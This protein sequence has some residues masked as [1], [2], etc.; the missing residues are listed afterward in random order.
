ML[1]ALTV[2]FGA[3]FAEA[4]VSA[5]PPEPAK[6]DPSAVSATQF[7][8]VDGD[9]CE[10][11]HKGKQALSGALKIDFA[12][13]ILPHENT[14]AVLYG[15]G[16]TSLTGKFD[17][18]QLP[19]GWLCDVA[20]DYEKPEV[21]AKNFRPDHA[22][23]FPGA[24]GFGKYTL[25][26]R[27]G[28]VIAVTNLNDSGPGS[29]RAA[30]KAKGPRI[31][32]FNVS[33]TIVLKSE[34]EIK[35]PYITIAGQ[36]APGDGICVSNH[37]VQ[38]D[39][40]DVVIRYMRFRPGAA[41]GVTYDGFGGKGEQAIIDHC[42]VSWGVD[43]VF[44]INKVHNFT[45]Q[46]CMATES[47]SNSIHKKG[48]HGYGG[49]WGGPGGSWH[50]NILAHHS[51]RNPRA[52]GNVD[53]GLMDYRNN[54][55]YNWGYQ[56]AYGGELWP[57]NWINNYYKSG[58]ATDK[59]V[60]HRIFI[61][62]NSHGR[63]Y[64]DGNFVVGYPEISKDNWS[65]G[66]D[67][68]PDGDATEATLRVNEP[69]VVAPVRTQPAEEAYELVLKQAGAS[70]SRDSV[71]SRIINEIRTGTAK[72]GATYGGGGKGIIDSPED[73]GGW[74]ALKS[75]LAPTDTDADGMPDDWEISHGLDPKQAK[76][77]SADRDGDGYTNVEEYINS[78]APP[79]YST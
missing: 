49:L 46:W 19:K 72:F 11:I 4:K 62:A 14:V 54:V 15:K 36:T 16:V 17:K 1:I 53:S 30:C 71:D 5:L 68:S 8:I 67:F 41:S 38:F 52:S 79:V 48:K 55:V 20:Y 56:S 69:F 77:G 10:S 78:L 22:P 66:I 37:A 57:R 13:R 60:K 63:M 27:G 29:L 9:K 26:G 43:E 7:T 24:E 73:V 28:R 33:G 70:R 21:V 39:T 23:A 12:G 51:S 64:C 58:P 50:H 31:V 2:F 75:T 32:V 25:G 65:G 61:Q 47:L 76:D 3:D 34:L 45:V 6:V 44:S 40:H 18:V 59:K 74:P 42:S 35:D